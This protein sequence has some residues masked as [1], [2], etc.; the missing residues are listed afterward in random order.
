M[1]RATSMASRRAS[2]IAATTTTT[3][4]TTTQPGTH[5]HSHT[6]S[7]QMYGVYTTQRDR[8]CSPADCYRRRLFSSNTR[9]TDERTNERTIYF[10][11]ADVHV[12]STRRRVGA[13]ICVGTA[14][15]QRVRVERSQAVF[16]VNSYI[17]DGSIGM[18]VGSS[19]SSSN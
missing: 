2:V 16:S 11:R 5:T 4:T 15:V 7:Q 12:G 19:S 10:A 3:T 9:R 1:K 18:T 8:S 6:R 14:A 17:S 13:T